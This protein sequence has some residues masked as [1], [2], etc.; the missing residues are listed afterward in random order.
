MPWF[1]PFVKLAQQ[2]AKKFDLA[3]RFTSMFSP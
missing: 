1:E 3:W 2:L